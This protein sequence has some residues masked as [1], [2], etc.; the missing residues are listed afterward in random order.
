MLRMI[1][2]FAL[3]IVCTSLAVP[4]AGAAAQPTPD[5]LVKQVTLEVL[6]IVKRD[7]DIQAGDH[8]KII[9]LVEE[10]VLPHFDFET[11][12]RIAMGRNWR[13][14]SPEQRKRLVVEFK[15]LLVRTYSSAISNYQDEK[16]EFRPLRAAPDATD[17][18]V[19]VRVIQPGREAVAIDYDMENTPDGWKCYNVYVA[20]VS[21]VAN[22]RTEFDAEVR[23]NGVE[24]LLKSLEAKNKSLEHAPIAGKK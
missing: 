10:K 8:K 14:A 1:E 20:G 5:V 7:R 11:M 17:V 22:Y 19:N 4:V 2:R 23:K 18:T 3:L 6:D 16:F 21:L 15:T 24:G 13:Q 9:A 12:T